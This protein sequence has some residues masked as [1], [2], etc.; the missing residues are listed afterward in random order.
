MIRQPFIRATRK[1]KVE[2]ARRSIGHVN[3]PEGLVRDVCPICDYRGRFLTRAAITGSRKRA[4]CTRCGALERH[5]LQHLVYRV[6]A[7]EDRLR[8]SLLEVAPES[9]SVSGLHPMFSSVI[10]TDL[11]RTDIDVRTDL[12]RLPFPNCC[13]DVVVA[14]HVLEHIL[15]ADEAIAEIARILRP[16]GIA[17]LPVP[18]VNRR[19]AEY[20]SPNRFEDFHVRAPGPDFYDRYIGPFVEV[21]RYRS[22]DF[23]SVYQLFLLEDRTCFPSDRFPNRDHW[24]GGAHEDIMAVAM[25]GATP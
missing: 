8:G 18:I 16:G 23:S 2:L 20:E 12:T 3:L 15:A 17:V 9:F 1:I 13:F 22:S 19:T 10:T 14:S 21:V 25:K 6:L 7:S 5:R 11:L 24:E 4:Q